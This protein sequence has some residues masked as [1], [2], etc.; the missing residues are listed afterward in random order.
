MTKRIICLLVASILLCICFAGCATEPE[1][2][3][4]DIV[5]KDGNCYVRLNEE[6]KSG[7]GNQSV[8]DSVIAPALRFESLEQ[9]REQ[10]LNHDLDA[11]NLRWLA[12]FEKDEN[13]L[14]NIPDIN[15]L[16]CPV[17]PDE[18][19]EMK[20]V[21]ILEEK[22][23]SVYFEL[24]DYSGYVAWRCYYDDG[25]Y[26]EKYDWEHNWYPNNCTDE[27]DIEL[28]NGISAKRYEYGSGEKAIIYTLATEATT[29]FVVEYYGYAT[30]PVVVYA[31]T[32]PEYG[33]ILIEFRKID[34]YLDILNAMDF[35]TLN[36]E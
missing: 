29:F 7:A 3:D 27:K 18:L 22:R 4:Y 31:Y 9:M 5:Y 2:E 26:A 20:T 23:Y 32:N 10:F 33:N 17:V 16:Y 24:S 35:K 11:E 30:E 15:V 12:E 34:S 28:A 14:I 6:L 1:V 25:A 13:G 8:D 19:L 36:E 21:S